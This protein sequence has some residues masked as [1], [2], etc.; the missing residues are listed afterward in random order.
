MPDTLS[1]RQLNR[2]LLA[3]QHLLERVEMAPEAMVGHLVGMQAQIPLAPYTGLWTRI[4]GFQPEPVGRLVQ[5]RRLVRL[6]V[7]RGTL[8]LVTDDDA[9][10]IRPVV[11]PAL[12]RALM[13]SSPYGRAVDG[14][15]LDELVRVGRALVEENAMSV[16]DLGRELHERWPQYQPMDLAYSVQYRTGLVQVPAR[17]VWGKTSAAKLTTTTSFLG[18]EES[19]ET[20]PD[21][22]IMRYLAALGPASP[23]DAQAWCGLTG[24][25]L[26]F[27]RL[28]P[29]LRTFRD[30]QG[31]ELFDITDAVYPDEDT[32]GPVRFLPDYDN[33][34]LGHADRTRI[35]SDYDRKRAG[36]G[37]AVLLVDGFAK[38]TWKLDRQRDA[39]TVV[40]DEFEAFSTAARAAIEAEGHELLQFLAPGSVHDV[41][42]VRPA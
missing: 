23:R 21:E 3:R 2:T 14:I 26:V 27:E 13:Q 9:L 12:T 11:Q 38:A 15:D 37:T 32:P 33:V 1:L 36:I 39:V 30:E 40:V 25:P 6:P 31:R 34:C 17:G 7:M 5:E 28:G 29:R 41:R 18:R 35:V 4:A 24:M 8:H 22:L 16:S 10:A 20:T 19:A 42:F